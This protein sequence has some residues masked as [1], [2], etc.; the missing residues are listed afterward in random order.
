MENTLLE[1]FELGYLA[2]TK[3]KASKL[4]IINKMDIILRMFFTH[5]RLAQSTH[6]LKDAGYAE[7]SEGALEIGRMIGNWIKEINPPASGQKTTPSTQLFNKRP[8]APERAAGNSKTQKLKNSKA[9]KREDTAP[10]SSKELPGQ[11]LP[12][13]AP[14]ALVPKPSKLP[15]EER[16]LAQ[17]HP[18][19]VNNCLPF[20]NETK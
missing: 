1:I 11:I 2:L 8:F 5:L 14:V 15:P 17:E 6:C 18:P 13:L 7:L 16:L 4:L 3:Q 19:S 12:T 9:Q 20:L 10:R